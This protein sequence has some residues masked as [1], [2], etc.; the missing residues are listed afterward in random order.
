MWLLAL[1]SNTNWYLTQ[2]AVLEFWRVLGNASV[3]LLPGQLCP[4]VF[5]PVM[6]PSIDQYKICLQIICITY[7][8]F[9]SYNSA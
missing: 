9:L 4:G 2:I 1:L 3:Q 8:Y 6:V 7:E 5:V